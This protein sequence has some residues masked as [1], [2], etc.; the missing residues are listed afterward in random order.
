[1]I[2]LDG[3]RLRLAGYRA[4]RVTDAKAYHKGAATFGGSA[5]ISYF[6][7]RNNLWIIAKNYEL[8]NALLALMFTILVRR[9]L[10][11]VR[12][13]VRRD[14]MRARYLERGFV[15]GLRG[16]RRQFCKRYAVQRMRKLSDKELFRKF[17]EARWVI[18]FPYIK[19]ARIKIQRH[20]T[21]A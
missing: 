10:S 9:P 5:V 8:R 14:R 7:V 3:W 1:V 2:E 4:V 13:L 17:P 12:F 18:L 16:L 6:D 19:W 21:V 15:E 11:L 20:N